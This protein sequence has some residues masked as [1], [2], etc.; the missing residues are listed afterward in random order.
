MAARIRQDTL[1]LEFSA[2][3]NP[4]NDAMCMR[5]ICSMQHETFLKA[6][7]KEKKGK[8]TFAK[9][10]QMVIKIEKASK[11]A[12]EMVNPTNKTFSKHVM[13]QKVPGRTTTNQPVTKPD[14]TV[15]PCA[16]CSETDTP[17]K[18]VIINFLCVTCVKKV[19]H[20]K[21]ACLKKKI[22]HSNFKPSNC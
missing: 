7:S 4:Q 21:H 19:G 3:N 6:V 10:I 14:V 12:K 1:T 2:I 18:S 20:I 17:V 8:L 22:Q 15:P 9:A 11:V 16:R 5:F 13:P